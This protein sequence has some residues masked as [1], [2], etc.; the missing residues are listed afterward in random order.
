[1]TEDLRKETER[2]KRKEG[3]LNRWGFTVVSVV[4]ASVYRRRWGW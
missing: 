4:G 2:G 1:M 3:D